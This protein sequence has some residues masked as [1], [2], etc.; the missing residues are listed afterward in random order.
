MKK[1]IFIS[2]DLSHTLMNLSVRSVCLPVLSMNLFYIIN[3]RT[4]RS[5]CKQEN[6]FFPKPFFVL[7]I[8][9]IQGTLWPL[10]S[11]PWLVM[12]SCQGT[13]ISLR[14]NIHFSV[15]IAHV[16]FHVSVQA[17]ECGTNGIL[18]CII[19]CFHNTTRQKRLSL[20]AYKLMHSLLKF[21]SQIWACQFVTSALLKHWIPSTDF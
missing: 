13:A 14:T 6:P 20:R 3:Y 21:H 5:E 17:A 4:E 11:L 18:G 7:N 12:G 8:L 16:G 1:K 2:P 9:I 10:Q 19:M 15:I